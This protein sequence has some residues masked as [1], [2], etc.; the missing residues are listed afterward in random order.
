MIED[1]D[2]R[3][4]LR[5]AKHRVLA[6]YYYELWCGADAR[7][8]WNIERVTCRECKLRYEEENS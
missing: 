5:K 1:L 3:I 4:H 7:S 2:H 6:A 8:A